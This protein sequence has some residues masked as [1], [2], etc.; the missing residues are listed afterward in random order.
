M[1]SNPNNKQIL[2]DSCYGTPYICMMHNTVAGNAALVRRTTTRRSST[3]SSISSLSLED[4]K[5]TTTMIRQRLD[6]D[7]LERIGNRQ[8]KVVTQD[9]SKSSYFVVL[10]F[11]KSES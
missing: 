4:T 11:E 5:Q 8:L 3:G 7:T 1:L 9:K 2:F 10:T 6:K